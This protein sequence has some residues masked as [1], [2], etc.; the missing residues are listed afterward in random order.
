MRVLA[1]MLRRGD[2]VVDGGEEREVKAVRQ[3]GRDVIV[4]FKTGQP[5]RL[6]TDRD[7]RVQRDWRTP[8]R[9]DHR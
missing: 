3:A 7:L 9:R 8:R 6:E 4:V 5:L 2:V 1:Y